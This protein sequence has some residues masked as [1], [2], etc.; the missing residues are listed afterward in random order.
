MDIGDVT[1]EQLAT[2]RAEQ[3]DAEFVLD[4]SESVHVVASGLIERAIRNVLRN[5]VEHND[6]DAIKIDITL[7][8]RP[9]EGEVELRIADN[10]PGIPDETIEVLNADQEEQMKHLSGFGLWAVQWVLTLSGGRLEFAENGPRGT[11]AKLVLPAAQTENQRRA[12]H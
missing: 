1:R 12:T 4:V 5:A 3:T 10:G 9:E 6:A 7:H 8:R 11:V 2:L